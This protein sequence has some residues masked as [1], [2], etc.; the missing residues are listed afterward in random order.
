[1]AVAQM[2]RVWA[3]QQPR[4]TCPRCRMVSYNPHD[5]IE[6][7]CGNCHDWTGDPI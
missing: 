4:F 5:I 3:V 7:Y 6:G 1:L 2:E